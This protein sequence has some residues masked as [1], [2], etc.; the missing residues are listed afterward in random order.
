ML[1]VVNDHRTGSSRSAEEEAYA[2]LLAAIRNGRLA[3][4]THIAAERVS[5]ELG[6]SRIPV[7]EALRRLASEGFVTL[8]SN[9]GA[10]VARFSAAEVLELYEMR[11]VLEGLAGRY[12]TLAIDERGLLE[13]QAALARLDRARADAEWFVTAHNQ[14][15]DLINAYCPRERLVREIVRLR[16]AAEPFLRM[17]LRHSPTAHDATV[18]EHALLFEVLASRDPDRCEVAMRAHILATD[19]LRLLPPGAVAEGN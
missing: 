2:F 18:A 8:K 16:T 17:T 11:A 15:H 14:L 5:A 19:V 13:G 4:G 12:S 1:D 9:R 6:I 10:F 7:R 3:A